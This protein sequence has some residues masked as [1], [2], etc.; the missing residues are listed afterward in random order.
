MR[1]ILI[2]TDFSGSSRAAVGYGLELAER[3]G[4][5]AFL[6][7]V[8]EEHP[9]CLHQ[10]GGLP[11]FL[12]DYIDL[13][14][15]IAFYPVRQRVIYRDLSEEAQWKLEAMVPL[16]YQDRVR[17]MVTVGKVVDEII[18]VAKEQSIDLIMMGTQQRGVL[19][20]LLRRTL[21]ERVRRKAAI[22]VIVVGTDRWKLRGADQGSN[23]QPQG[24]EAG[25]ARID[26]GY[27]PQPGGRRRPSKGSQTVGA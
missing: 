5:E 24:L 26:E 14:G 17:L 7:H 13:D 21:A 12:K 20:H 10:V 1:R 4:G 27:P 23:A 18:H 22:P 16:R 9:T 3:V 11:A 15:S 2:P 19:R 6:L 8:V 25:G